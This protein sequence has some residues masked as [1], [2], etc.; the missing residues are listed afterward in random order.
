VALAE[1]AWPN[2]RGSPKEWL[3]R[4]EAEH[5]NLR[6]ALDG[7]EKSGESQLA[8]RLSG[9]LSRFWAMRG[10]LTEGR[11]RLQSAL[12][13]DE[14]PTAARA[15]AL[16]GAA[17]VSLEGG[18]P[19]AGRL[20]A[21]AGLALHR[22]LADTW[23]TAHSRF[24]LGCADAEEGEYKRGQQLF[25]ESMRAFHEL[26]DEHYT[27]LSTRQLAWMHFELGN[28]ERAR[29]LHEEVVRR[30]RLLHNER[31]EAT[32]LG[33]LAEYAIY[34]GRLQ[35]ALPLLKESTRIYRDL[36][37]RVATA[38]NL[39]RFARAFAEEGRAQAAARLLA[40]SDALHEEAG[41]SGLASWA[42]EMN[43]ETLAAIRTRLDE[44]AFAEAWEQGRALTI[45]EAVALVLE[46]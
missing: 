4:L 13:T 32:S 43:D 12:R 21:E 2:L 22:T 17:L 7:L 40:C 34:E 28:R 11:R 15:K 6:A 9:A 45:D 35:V 18:D 46:S 5:D 44:A 20:W 23:G 31:M 30:A 1:E 26:G 24:L 27:L 25:E 16:N 42:A 19:A 8:L 36:G 33:A 10:H 37:D 3:D 14:R 41:A 38:V 39:C 29:E